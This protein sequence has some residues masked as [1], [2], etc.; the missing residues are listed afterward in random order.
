MAWSVSMATASGVPLYPPSRTS[1]RRRCRSGTQGPGSRPAPRRRAGLSAI[2]AL[3][4]GPGSSRFALVRDGRSDEHTSE[5]QSL[6]RLSYAV[7]VLKKKKNH[8][9]TLHTT[10]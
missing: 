2:G 6:M 5:L 9:A 8:I 4:L 10:Y 1:R 7:F 3:A